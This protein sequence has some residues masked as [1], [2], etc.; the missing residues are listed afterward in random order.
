MLK[1]PMLTKCTA[2]L[3]F[4]LAVKPTFAVDVEDTGARLGPAVFGF[5]GIFTKENMGSSLRPLHTSYE[6]NFLGGIGYQNFMY[7]IGNVSLGIEAGVS[8]RAGRHFTGEVWSGAVGRYDGLPAVAGFEV[9]PAFTFGLSA[10][11]AAH[12]GRE[13]ILEE[14]Y[15]GDASLLF[16]LGPEINVSRA[17]SDREIFWRLHHRSGAWGTLGNMKGAMNANVLGIRQRF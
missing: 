10:V 4:L 8:V 2:L 11:T 1:A 16:Y 6:S 17:N 3:L 9:S 5:G 7:N 12:R 13:Q 15:G 14:R